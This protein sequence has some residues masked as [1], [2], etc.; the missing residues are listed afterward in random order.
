MEPSGFNKLLTKKAPH[1]YEKIL[2]SLDYASFKKCLEVSTALKELLTSESS[3]VRG[4][5]VFR[6]EILKDEKTLTDASGTVYKRNIVFYRN[7]KIY[8]E[9]MWVSQPNNY[10]S[11]KIIRFSVFP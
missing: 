8:F 3:I 6:E 1:I 4:K 11:A 9:K 10:V 2:L 7:G 5:M